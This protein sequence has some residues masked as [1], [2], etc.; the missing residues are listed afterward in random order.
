M[1]STPPS[2]IEPPAP[3][4]PKTPPEETVVYLSI[5]NPEHQPI[6]L[7][8]RDWAHEFMRGRHKSF[9]NISPQNALNSENALMISNHQ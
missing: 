3:V 4:Q 6:D 7:L 8:K 5:Q 1:L 9:D 2:T